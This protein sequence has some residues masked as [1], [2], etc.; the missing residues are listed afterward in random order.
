MGG[1]VVNGL[2]M[3]VWVVDGRHW[4]G[5]GCVGSGWVGSGW[6]GRVLGMEGSGHWVDLWC[7]ARGLRCRG[8]VRKNMMIENKVGLR[9]D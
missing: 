5:S 1:W 7:D 6:V 8:G 2:V 4:A 9:I 3:H